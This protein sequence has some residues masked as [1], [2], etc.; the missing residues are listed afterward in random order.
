MSPVNLYNK[1]IK[2]IIVYYIYIDQNI[3]LLYSVYC[4]VIH[5]NGYVYTRHLETQRWA[6]GIAT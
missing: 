2:N 4:V 3:V 6:L 5:S 1:E